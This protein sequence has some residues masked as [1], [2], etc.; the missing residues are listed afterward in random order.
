MKIQWWQDGIHISPEN[1]DE[2]KA[3]AT[4]FTASKVVRGRT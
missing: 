1:R 3:L 2:R 4:L